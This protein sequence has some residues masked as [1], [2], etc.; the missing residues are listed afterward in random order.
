MIH[1]TFDNIPVYINSYQV[2]FCVNQEI[3]RQLR[4]LHPNLQ[5]NIASTTIIPIT[6]TEPSTAWMSLKQTNIAKD[7]FTPVRFFQQNFE[8]LSPSSPENN[9]AVDELTQNES[10]IEVFSLRAAVK[11]TDIQSVSDNSFPLSSPD[12]NS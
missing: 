12:D 9:P 1:I 3:F 11:E 10:D 2:T 4:L 5:S 6:L 8:N 7:D